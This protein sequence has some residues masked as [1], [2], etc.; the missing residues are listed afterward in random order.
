MSDKTTASIAFIGAGTHA[1][2]SLYPNIPQIPEFKLV[3]VCDMNHERADHWAPRYGAPA[4]YDVETM[5]DA[6]APEG[7]CIVGP[8]EMHHAVALQVLARGIPVFVEKPPATTLAGAIELAD[9]ARASG[10]WGMVAFM[11]RFAPANAVVREWTPTASAPSRPSASSTA[12][13]PTAILPP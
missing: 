7:V 4:F 12:P 10:T 11:K 13:A 3:A 1:T 9:A 5:I 2:Q 6:V 8:A